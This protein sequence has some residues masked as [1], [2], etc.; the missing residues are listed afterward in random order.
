MVKEAI[1][2]R[3]NAEFAFPASRLRNT[4]PLHPSLRRR[5]FRRDARSPQVSPPAFAALAPDLQRLTLFG[6]A[7]FAITRSLALISVASYPVSVRRHAV[8]FHAAFSADLA[9]VALHFASVPATR[10]SPP[11]RW[12][13]W[14]HTLTGRPTL[15]CVAPCRLVVLVGQIGFEPT[16]S[17][18]RSKRSTKLSHCPS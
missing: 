6:R 5:P 11:S 17:C 2:H 12:T 4:A 10:L 7:G 16:T 3:R 15:R 14:A 9:V 18:S 13:C 8:S 1:Q